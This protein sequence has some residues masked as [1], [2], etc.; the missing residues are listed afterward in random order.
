[1]CRTRHQIYSDMAQVDENS[2]Y[3]LS[4]SLIG[5]NNA[6]ASTSANDS[7]LIMSRRIDAGQSWYFRKTSTLGYYRLHTKQKGDSAALDVFNYNGKNSICL[8]MYPVQD[9]TGQH[10]RFTKQ[11]DGSLRINN[12]FTGPDIFLDVAND[13]FKP[14]LAAKYGPGQSCM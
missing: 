13:T 10:W 3:V 5:F 8:H 1:L 4:N 12:L 11:D 6:L 7:I 14:R 9:N 2:V